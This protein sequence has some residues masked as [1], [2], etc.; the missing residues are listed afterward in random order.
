[1]KQEGENLIRSLLFVPAGS[2]RMIQK[3]AE[4]EADALILDLEDGTAPDR[5]IEARATV[6]RVLRETDFGGKDVF[7]RI[8]TLSSKLGLDD[9]RE[10]V[11]AGVRGIAIPKTESPDDVTSVAAILR[12]RWRKAEPGDSPK[13]LCLLETPR[14]VLDARQLAEVDD[15][16]VGV[17]FG[18]ADLSREIGSHPT[19]DEIELLY[20]RSH[21]IMAARAAGVAAWDSPHF[22]INDLEGL[23]R[24]CIAARNLGYDGKALI[25]PSHIETV[26]QIFRPSP[27]QIEEA[28]RLVAA[29]EAAQADGQ[30]VILHQGR[31]V[32]QVHLDAARKLIARA[33]IQSTN[34]VTP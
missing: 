9:A 21:I 6:A 25:H 20:A 3:A 18:S 13:I 32:D 8:N 10:A 31:M 15:L 33:G 23:R 17:I 30:G 16:V 27:E 2:E 19:E 12:S 5:K 14:G 34:K 7:V 22:V 4:S 26:N 1:M 24:R 11:A 29:M 28:E